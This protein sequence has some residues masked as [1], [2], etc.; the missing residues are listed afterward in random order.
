MWLARRG[1]RWPRDVDQRDLGGA[2]ADVEQHDAVGVVVDQ[3]AAARDGQPRLGLAVDDLEV[4]PGLG[5][6]AVEELARRFRPSGRPRWR[7]AASA[8]SAGCAS[9]SAQIFSAS[10]ARSMA[11]WP[12]RPLDDSP[13]PSL[14]MREN[15]SMTRN[16][17]GRVGTATSSRQLLVPRSSAAKTGCSSGRARPEGWRRRRGNLRV[18][19]VVL[20]CRRRARA[21][22]ALRRPHGAA[23]DGNRR[24]AVAREHLAAAPA[25]APLLAARPVVGSVARFLVRARC[26][27]ERGRHDRRCPG[28]WPAGGRQTHRRTASRLCRGLAPFVPSCAARTLSDA[29]RATIFFVARETSSDRPFTKW[30]RRFSFPG[31]AAARPGT[32]RQWRK[33]FPCRPRYGYPTTGETVLELGGRGAAGAECSGKDISGRSSDAAAVVFS[34]WLLYH[35]VRGISFTDVYR[36][37]SPRSRR[38]AWLL[39][40]LGTVIAYAAIAGY[41]N[42]ALAHIERKVSLLFVSLCSFTTYA[43]SHNIG[44]SVLSGAVIRYRAYATKGLSGRRDRRAGGGVLVHL[45]HRHDPGRQR[46]VH[47]LARTSRRASCTCCRSGCRRRPA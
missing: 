33:G 23:P 5:L 38:T 22:S 18:D 28:T 3:R 6:D 21:A 29:A 9:L 27:P 45:R 30:A 20:D 10:T 26:R 47:L 2:A 37:R 41:D 24:D 12:S 1:E 15:A 44:G 40:A 34:L 14:T 11:G 7:S 39:S 13:S 36:R 42:I 46:A 43:L 25:L 16:W 32:D 17:P 4:E 8:G 19:P 35:E 31:K